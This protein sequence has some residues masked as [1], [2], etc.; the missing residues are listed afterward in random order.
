MHLHPHYRQ[1]CSTLDAFSDATLPFGISSGKFPPHEFEYEW[2]GTTPVG[3]FTAAMLIFNPSA[4]LFH[5]SLG[6]DQN[7]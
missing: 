6:R 2:N 1:R 5:C 4:T 3:V 7:V